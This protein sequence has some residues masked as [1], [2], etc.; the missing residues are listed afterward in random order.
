MILLLRTDKPEAELYLYENGVCLAKLI[1]HAHRELSDT[2]LIKIEELLANNNSQLKDLRGIAFIKVQ[3]RL[4]GC[5]G[6][7]VAN[8]LAYSLNIPNVGA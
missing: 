5:I 8:A 3:G 7:S 6:I 1:W 4:L 2:L